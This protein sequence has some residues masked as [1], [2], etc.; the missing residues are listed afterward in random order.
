MD[1][2][3]IIYIKTFVVVNKLYLF[4]WF[5]AFFWFFSTELIRGHAGGERGAG[6]AGEGVDEH[7][8][9]TGGGGGSSV[10]K[11]GYT[12]YKSK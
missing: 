4:S 11:T 12:I 5:T 1:V 9:G 7:V 6:L 8:G 10:E 2:L 3:I